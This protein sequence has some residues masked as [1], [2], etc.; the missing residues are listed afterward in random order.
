VSPD[1]LLNDL[2][3]SGEYRAHLIKVL[4]ARAVARPGEVQSFK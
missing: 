3:G 1:E 2:N 4:C